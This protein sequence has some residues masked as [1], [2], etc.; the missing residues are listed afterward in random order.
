MKLED[1]EARHREQL[2][3]IAPDVCNVDSI[4]LGETSGEDAAIAQRQKKLEQIRLKREMERQQEIE[5]EREEEANNAGPSPRD[6]EMN[7]IL[8]QLRPLHLDI[9]SVPA[10]GNCLYRAV[11]A[12]YRTD[13]TYQEIRK[14]IAENTCFD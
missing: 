7:Q 14:C 12:Q 13:A 2:S 10:D 11:A 6:I 5:R 9:V 3:A 8:E 1:I 4:Q